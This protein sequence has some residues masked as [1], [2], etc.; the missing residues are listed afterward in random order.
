MGCPL[1]MRWGMIATWG[2]SS[3]RSPIGSMRRD[4]LRRVR[5]PNVAVASVALT[6][7]VAFPLAAS[8][9]PSAPSGTARPL[10]TGVRESEAAGDS[11]GTPGGATTGAGTAAGAGDAL[12]SGGASAALA[13][14]A[15]AGAD[16][17]GD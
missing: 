13:G 15:A 11:T 8:R 12:G 4:L 14:R 16:G 6:A 3:G 5:W 7:V 9:P 1:D 10:L 17:T 2:E